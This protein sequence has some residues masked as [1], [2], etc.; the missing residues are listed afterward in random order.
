MQSFEVKRGHGKTLEN[1]GLKSLMEEEFGEVQEAENLFTAS[2]KAL[3]NINV[4]FVSITEIRVKTETDI[5]ASPEDSL[6]AHQAYNRFMEAATS[7]NAKQR[8]DR[9][10]AKAKKEA[11]AAA[12]KE[13]AAEKA[14]EES[15]EEPAE[16]ESSEEESE[17]S[18]EEP[19]EEKEEEETS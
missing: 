8:V 12:E 18:E 5:E 17:E 2:F 7:F 15:T 14:A 10:K 3:K 1:G 11:K 6:D 4:E 19:A 13:M 16:E 9:A